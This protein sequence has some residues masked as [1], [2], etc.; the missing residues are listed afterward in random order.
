[1]SEQ[2]EHSIRKKLQDADIPFD[3]A[4]WEQMKKRLD[5][6]DR[7][8]PA[9]FWWML[10][11]LLILTLAGGSFWWWTNNNSQQITGDQLSTEKTSV[12]QPSIVPHSQV[13]SSAS[14]ANQSSNVTNSGKQ[15]SVQN[16]NQSLVV[17]NNRKT[18][19]A[20]GS[21]QSS[22]ATINRH[23]SSTPGSNQTSI[24]TNK[25]QPPSN[26]DQSSAAPNNREPS[27]TPTSDQPPIVTN[28][29]VPAE[30]SDTNHNVNKVPSPATSNSTQ[31]QDSTNNKKPGRKGLEAGI[32][33][34]PDYNVAAS[35]KRG[36]VGF[37]FG[38]ILKYN[39][40]NRWSIQSGAIYN[41]K[42]YGANASEYTFTYPNTYKWIAADCNV[43]D[44]P[45][46]VFY[47]FSENGRNRWSAMAGAS[48]YFMLKE[49][50]D[51]WYEN[52]Y[53]V[54]H[55][56]KNQHQHYLSVLNLGV[57]WERQTIGRLR[58]SLQPYVKV[59][60]GGVGQGSIKLYT[61]G[62]ALQLTMGKK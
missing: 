21:N 2:F 24:V 46:N 18:S 17:T 11:G 26:T 9:I 39:F 62:L 16:F 33:L 32:T 34:G 25:Q 49:K 57:N 19:S 29:A 52:G 53:K 51:Y 10:S 42:L 55:E 22:V 31:H 41:K 40:S 12:D 30:K 35:L 45:L 5:D 14:N 38:I 43:L 13:P 56:Y 6:S 23:S 8:R 50:Y 47:T 15:S 7:R 44:V 1:M 60:L 36:K 27:E 59:P 20:S 4:A 61:A 37:N 58:W 54:S 48:S 28:N 3:P